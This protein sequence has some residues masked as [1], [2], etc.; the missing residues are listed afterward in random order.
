MTK[1]CSDCK[2]DKARDEFYADKHKKCGL[3]T[4]CKDCSRA[5]QR[6]FRQRRST[7]HAERYHAI[8]DKLAF[9]QA[10]YGRNREKYLAWRARWGSSTVGRLTTVLCSARARAKKRGL[11][12]DLDMEWLAGLW[13]LQGGRCALTGLPMETPFRAEEATNKRHFHPFSPSLDRITPGLGY[14]KEN[15]RLVCTAINLALNEFGGDVFEQ[16]A[17]GY[18]RKGEQNAD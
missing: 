7:Y 13:E 15:T 17:K 11:P 12:F 2:T 18:L 5:R 16:I 10:R 3:Q 8:D 6:A 1:R 4:R 14:T 9:N